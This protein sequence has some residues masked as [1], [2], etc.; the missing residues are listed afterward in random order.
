MILKTVL[1]KSVTNVGL[2]WRS[3]KMR[4]YFGFV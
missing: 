1:V 3:S 4:W 2:C